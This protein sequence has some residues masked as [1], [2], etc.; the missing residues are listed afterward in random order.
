MKAAKLHL[1]DTGL[2]CHLLGS[3]ARRIQEDRS[4]LGRMLESF[5]VGELRK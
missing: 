5:V 2:A 3:D 4:L 1:V